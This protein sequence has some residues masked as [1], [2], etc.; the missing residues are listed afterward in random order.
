MYI[1]NED[2]E[3]KFKSLYTHP[4]TG[5]REYMSG[6]DLW[7]KSV[8]GN[9]QRKNSLYTTI[10]FLKAKLREVDEDIYFPDS[11]SN[12]CR[13]ALYTRNLE[14]LKKFRK[15]LYNSEGACYDSAE[16]ICGFRLDF[17]I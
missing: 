2:K 7:D 15:H 6:D 17:P 12:Q 1:I 3:F 4:D 9:M 5:V 13:R 16:S 14:G 10:A 8:N 11:L